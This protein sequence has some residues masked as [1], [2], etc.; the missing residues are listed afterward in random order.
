MNLTDEQKKQIAAWVEA[1]A[2]LSEIQKR[3]KEELGIPMT[4][5]DARLLVLELGAAV[6][7]KPEPKQ[8]KP[9]EPDAAPDATPEENDDL[10][11]DFESEAL[12][13]DGGAAVSVTLDRVVIPGAMVSGDVV[14]SDGERARWLIDQMGRF[15]L[16]PS[17]PG[18]KPR[19]ADLQGFQMEL[20]RLLQSQGMC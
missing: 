15:G 19:P 10:P 3:L 17:T 1:G 4:Y 9:V 16:E 7:D 12:P 14:F 8:Q 11:E 6:K 2:S 13:A 20:R 18:Y 5:M